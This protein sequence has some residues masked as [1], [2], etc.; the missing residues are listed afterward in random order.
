MG[1][2]IAAALVGMALVLV[3]A[4]NGSAQTEI[5]VALDSVDAGQFPAMSARATVTDENGLPVRG[6]TAANFELVEDGRTSFPPDGLQEVSDDG[7]AVSVLI[8][9]DLGSTMSGGPLDAA[10]AASAGFVEALLNQPG[11][12]DRAAF[13]GFGSQVDITST[14][15]TD[16][17]REVAFTGDSGQLLNVI[18][19]VAAEPSG[20]TP[21]YDSIYRAIKIA[22]QQPGR[23][24]IIV[25]TDGRDSGSTLKDD[26]PITEAQRQR[27]PVFAVGLSNSRLDTGYLT[28]LAE[29]TGGSFQEAPSPEELSQK[30]QE[31]LSD[32]KL[33]YL[34]SYTS[35]LAEQ[36]GQV[37]S[38]LLRVNAGAGQAFDE[39][40]LQLGEPAAP[41]A[42]A[43]SEPT[44]AASAGA[45]AT[46][47]PAA[48][49]IAATSTV[50]TAT[51][52]V[53]VLSLAATPE[54][55]QSEGDME[56]ITDV[57]RDNPLLIVVIAA[58]LFLFLVLVILVIWFM[59]RRSSKPQQQQP[60]YQPQQYYTPPEPPAF[61]RPVNTPKAEYETSDGS[62]TAA[63][64]FGA[65]GERST[66]TETEAGPPAFGPSRPS[67]GTP[68]GQGA[69]GSETQVGPGPS[70]AESP[71]GQV[72]SA[73]P[74]GATTPPAGSPFAP[75][76][77]QSSTPFGAAQPPAAPP[78]TPPAAP[79]RVQ[80]EDMGDET[81][82][83]QRAPKVT[84][85]GLLINR[86]QP[87]NRYDVD[88]PT[89]SVGRAKGNVIVLDN[90]T[91][92]RQHATIKLEGDK[93]V[94]YDLG[95][96]NGTFV[97][98]ERVR[99]PVSLEDGMVVRFGELE[100]TFKLMSL[101]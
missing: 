72:P 65:V 9:V 29:L 62:S 66:G 56:R 19:F 7:A 34:L 5:A 8:L 6:L 53:A 99:E 25:M 93:F 69:P 36:D 31:V 20:G 61:P 67:S 49:A 97:G 79:P 82:V 88:K 1:R 60:A 13:I 4:L 100:F 76:Q 14:A 37:H 38:L 11:D 22:A 77:P 92:S 73:S 2:R 45:T 74:F 40:K 87:S 15:I 68:F 30:F 50:A 89:V 10:R 24:A 57:L 91:V 96:A 83:M 101:Q 86:K 17:S 39:A 21:L 47:P 48:T 84:L 81:V 54:T 23:R 71:F 16:A 85:L 98:D 12:P 64:G 41:T 90:P 43:A 51:A 63:T 80:Q 35:R 44:A 70:P 95:S 28:R 58:A 78:L 42:T 46:A 32:L 27:I 18:N 26:D 52:T 59:R 75:S 94:L 33:Q 55:A 3:P